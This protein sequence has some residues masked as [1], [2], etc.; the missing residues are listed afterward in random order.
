MTGLK[1]SMA[2]LL[3]ILSF[4][5]SSAQYKF[6]DGLIKKANLFYDDYELDSAWNLAVNAENLSKSK[7]YPKGIIQSKIIQTNIQ[8]EN[9]ELTDAETNANEIL[10][11]SRK[12][13]DKFSEAVANMQL[14]QVYLYSN[15]FEKAVPFFEKAI[16]NYFSKNP[17][18]EAALAYNDYGYTL[19]KL[20]KLELQLE[21]LLNALRIN[22]NLKPIDNYEIA[23]VL[24]NLSMVYLELRQTEK[25]IDFA[26]QSISYREKTE[27][28]DQLAL[29]YCNISQMYRYLN[30]TES[31]KYRK[32]CV[33]F[34]E[35]SNNE[36][37]LVQSYITSALIFSDQ[38]A[39]EKA[40]ENEKK[41]IS[42]L[43]KSH[44]S[45]NLLASRYL[46]VA[47]HGINLQS[48][49]AEIKSYLEKSKTLALE[50]KDRPLLREIYFN[51]YNFYKNQNDFENALNSYRTFNQYRDSIINENTKSNIA[52][53]ETKYETEKKDNQIHQLSTD[54]KIKQLQIEKQN[55]LI[56]G[57][58]LEAERKEKEI[59]LLS[60][61]KE[62]Q[63]LRIGK[64]NE[65]I[66]KQKLISLSNNQKLQI[67]EQDKIIQGKKLKN[68]RNVQYLTFGLAGLSLCL[69]LILFN[70][71][72]L[73]RTIKEQKKL[74]AI[75]ENIAKDL[76]D[77]IGSTLTSIK[78]LSEVSDRNLKN[79]KPEVSEFLNQITEQS[80]Q[81]QQ[82][83]SD[84]VWSVNPQNDVLENMIIRMREFVSQTL[85]N[86]NIHTK[87]NV[88]ENLLQTN[89]KMEE[90]RDFLLIFK[91]AI[92][93]IAKHS[94]A[95]NVNIN[96]ESNSDGI[97]M[98]IT[99]NGKGF[100][101]N[102]IH[103]RNGLKNMKS[104]AESMN[105]D[106][107]ITSQM[108]QGTELE[109]FIKTTS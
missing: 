4:S 87:I 24:N 35:K 101:V 23:A 9:N 106:F 10:K 1:F 49:T 76:H 104:R 92:N 102:S 96:L 11:L 98:K 105:A 31:E 15:R 6:V 14:G 34:A 30:L 43:E 18:A 13:N 69:G 80:T 81:A 91:E 16:Q 109:L 103:S 21:N 75:R 99:D 42:I 52:E 32:L 19:G 55:A 74:L 90:R 62:L 83:I 46:S 68:S 53:L 107:K 36:S 60:Q 28:A 73:K 85:E 66:E 8:I 61:E 40:T 27:D 79:E 108:N 37:R 39:Y 77:E 72:Q 100:E 70:R 71:Y 94:D 5:M 56:A 3:L 95:T 33:E 48:D 12:S 54:Q 84:I 38:K 89:L 29:A 93:N 82:S 26:K 17:S 65:E 44:L 51:Y 47:I 63:E 41:A 59:Q 78:I 2:C 20:G 50:L 25:A 64:Q 97:L 57:N 7:N 58:L 22:E 86:K 45:P 88:D 67:A